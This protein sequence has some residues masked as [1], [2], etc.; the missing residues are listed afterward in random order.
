VSG[1]PLLVEAAALQVLVVGGGAVATRRA[2]QFL[3]AGASVRIVAPALASELEACVAQHSLQV[4]RRGYQA[5]DIG[6]AH[7]VIV[8]TNDRAVNA[9][10][11]ADAQAA[12]RLVNV[13]DRG[14]EGTFTTM[15]THRS[16]ALTIG[17]SAG[18]VP[19]AA[20]RIRDALAV[21][22]DV[23]YGE[24]L[25]ELRELR[26]ALIASGRAD[27]W[28]ERAT[29]VIDEQFCD[30]VEQGDLPERMASWR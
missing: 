22:F 16:G 6:D 23:R 11:A 13:A 7:L 28:R 12:R 2:K 17:V 14:D 5:G 27:L 1:V 26:R 19:S 24:A 25:K 21:R 10:V 3:S 15:A 20:S 4:E 30:A 9:A 29:A 18:G 8:A